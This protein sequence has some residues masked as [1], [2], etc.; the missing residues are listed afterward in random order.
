MEYFAKVME[1]FLKL[2]GVSFK[3]LLDEG[4]E[5]AIGISVAE[6]SKA[7]GQLKPRRGAFMAL[8][9]D[10]F[11]FSF[12]A[13]GMPFVDMAYLRHE[14]ISGGYLTYNRRKTLN[15]ANQA[16]IG[17]RRKDTARGREHR[18]PAS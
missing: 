10:L 9:R 4:T 2:V 3:H 13:L 6:G 5:L 1:Y 16:V 7:L 18:L 8:A 17:R 12:Y 11:L 15:K 14:Q